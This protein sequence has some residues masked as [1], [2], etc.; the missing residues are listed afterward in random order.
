[1]LIWNNDNDLNVTART[2]TRIYYVGK[3][4][5]YDN[6]IHILWLHDGHCQL[7]VVLYACV[8]GRMVGRMKLQ[9]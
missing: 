8:F 7:Q 3:Q 4:T 9:Q 5:Q 2:W 1:M 6:C